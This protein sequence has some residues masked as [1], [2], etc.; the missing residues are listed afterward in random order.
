MRVLRVAR[1]WVRVA[2]GPAQGFPILLINLHLPSGQSEVKE[3]NLAFR[4]VLKGAAQ[5]FEG[6]DLP[7]PLSQ[8][9][10]WCFGDLNY[11]LAAPA[12][13]VRWRMQCR[14]WP[15]CLASCQ[16]MSQ[17]GAGGSAYERFDEADIG[18]RPTY[19]YDIGSVHAFDT[20]E[21]QRPPA[22]TDRVLW[23]V[24]GKRTAT[25]RPLLYASCQTV[26]TSDHKP[27]KWLGAITMR[28][29]S[30]DER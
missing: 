24:G 3:R 14:D 27:V 28:R 11:R 10:T 30:D 4:E 15:S 23:R 21:K 6:L 19:K 8:H 16:L 29:A 22:W 17:I 7:A 13:E 9:A 25:I 2:C 18:F 26:T 5:A 1:A 12:K 20:S